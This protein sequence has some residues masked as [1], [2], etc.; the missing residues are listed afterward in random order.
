MNTNKQIIYFIPGTMCDERLWLKTWHE[1]QRQKPQAYELIHLAIPVVDTMAEVVEVLA[2]R[3]STTHAILLGFSLGG[4]VASA[5]ALKYPEKFSHLVV[6]SNIPQNLPEREIKQRLRTIDWI[7]NKGYGGIP[8]KRIYD[9]LHPKIK[10]LQPAHF[11]EIEQLIFAMDKTLG[12]Q[13]LMQQLQVSMR[14]R[15]LVTR[16]STLPFNVSFIVGDEDS[17]V[18]LDELKSKTLLAENIDITKVK[19]TGH[20]L[21]LEAPYELARLLINI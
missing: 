19:N 6:S 4:Y 21:P 13:V 11:L 12:E 3:I 1:L 9:L 10:L 18:D 20:M 8:T 15:A 7:N 17:L 2:E 16:L 14:R 5:L